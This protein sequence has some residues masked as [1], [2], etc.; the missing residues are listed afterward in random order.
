MTKNL[1]RFRFFKNTPL[2]DFQNTIHFNNN[3]ERDAFFLEGGHYSE[4]PID[5]VDF[6][7]IRDRSTIVLPISYDSMRGVNYCTFKSDFEETRYYAYVVNYEYKAPNT[8]KVYLLIDGIMTY[9]QGSVLQNL[10]NLSIQ[11]QHLTKASYNEN[12]WELKNNDDIIKTHTKAYFHT[13]RILFNELLV[14]MTSAVDLKGDFGTVDNPKMRTSFGKQFDGITSPLNLY[15]CDLDD[16]NRLML[17]LSDFAWISQNI[18]SLNLIPKI[19]ME[20]NLTR[21]N[22]NSND[23]LNG[24]TYLYEITG[25]KT[26]KSTLLQEVLNVS[27]TMDETLELFG[28]DPEQEKHLLRSEYTTTELY[29]YSGGQLFID[30]GQLN[31]YRGLNYWVD[32]ITGYHTEMKVY[33]D[34]YRARENLGDN[35]GSY[36][37]DSLVFNQFDDIPMLVDTFD[38][39][40][41]KN[42]NQRALAESKLVSNRISNVFDPKANLE[43]RF[44]N[45][46]NL[47]SNISP[48]SLFGRFA[49]EYDY[50]QTQK[51]EMADLALETPSITQQTTGNSFNI[52]NKMFGIHF[53]YSRPSQSEMNKIRKYYK[54][55]GYQVNDQSATIDRVDSMNICN[56]VQFTGSWTIPD[57]D[58]AII[59]MMKAQFQNGVR[60]WHNN[61][62][63]NPMT[64][65][66][67]NNI[68]I[69]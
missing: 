38:L 31:Q 54:L 27:Y 55:F 16:F 22:F 45:A 6:N 20:D 67:L 5:N 44:F 64:Q 36:V 8:V 60:L 61:N 21:I 10:P 50:Y 41:A 23:S 53:K 14:V 62:T 25:I 68:M 51:A 1:T 43:D 15:A 7:F 37:N 24:V 58:V 57:A 33:V 19:F 9:T 3:Y 69:R 46:A 59:E 48:V 39:A 2:I 40:L 13:D 56:Y 52:A 11:R 66:V 30:N 34:Q 26:S 18:R 42:A 12:L 32:I 35:T 28:L 63:P 29:N 65:N 4:I 49:D 17:A 47:I